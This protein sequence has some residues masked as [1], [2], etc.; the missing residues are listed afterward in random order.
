MQRR[1]LLQVGRFQSFSTCWLVAASLSADYSGSPYGA[2]QS[3]AFTTNIYFH[4]TCRTPKQILDAV[5][6]T[7]FKNAKFYVVTV[8]RQIPAMS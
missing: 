6:G 3:I 1:V 4:C 7:L 5:Q 8:G 2:E